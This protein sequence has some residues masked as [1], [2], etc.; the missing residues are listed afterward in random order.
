MDPLDVSEAAILPQFEDNPTLRGHCECV[1]FDPDR[2]FS[3]QNLQATA[4]GE[5]NRSY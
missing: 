1:E 3:I 5:G 2:T 4:P